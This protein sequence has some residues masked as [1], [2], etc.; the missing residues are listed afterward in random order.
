MALSVCATNVFIA[1]CCISGQF[2][3]LFL[4]WCYLMKYFVPRVRMMVLLL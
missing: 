1:D 4:V 3:S 2:Y